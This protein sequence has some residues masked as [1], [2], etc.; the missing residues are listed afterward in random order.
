MQQNSLPDQN[1]QEMADAMPG[2]HD[3][4][5]TPPGSGVNHKHG[6]IVT[7]L[8]RK[9]SG[10]P[11]R[12]SL[13]RQVIV[14]R[15]VYSLPHFEHEYGYEQNNVTLYDKMKEKAR[16]NCYCSRKRLLDM[17][18]SFFPILHWLPRYDWKFNFVPDLLAGITVGV[19]SVPQGMAFARIA[20][21]SP[22]NGLYINFIPTLVYAVLGTSQHAAIGGEAVNSLLMG[23]M[24]SKYLPPSSG[25]ATVTSM[26][27][28]SSL[29]DEPIT[30]TALDLAMSA[31]MLEGLILLVMGMLRLGFISVY[32]SDQLVGG[33]TTGIAVHVLSTQVPALFGLVVSSHQ[34][35]GQLLMHYIEL[36]SMISDINWSTFIGSVICISFLLSVKL[37]V[38]PVAKRKLRVPIPSELIVVIVGTV[39]SYFVKLPERY[40]TKVVGEIPAGFPVP[41]LPRFDLMEKLVLDTLILAIVA[42]SL[43]VSLSK[44]Y[45]KKH[46]YKINP[47]QEFFAYS[48]MNIVGSFFQ[49]WPASNST[50]RILIYEGAGAKSQ[51]CLASMIVVA[52]IFM[53]RSLKDLKPLWKTCK[54]DFSIYLVTFLSVVLLDVSYGLAVSV[55]YAFFTVIIR[56]QCPAVR[57]L[58]SV[59]HAG[60]YGE[61]E[62][63][64]KVGRHSSYYL[65]DKAVAFRQAK[66]M[67]GIR[68]FHFTA[69]LYYANVGHF[70]PK[71]YKRCGINPEL[72]KQEQEAKGSSI[73]NNNFHHVVLDCSG[74][75]YVDL[76]GVD[77]LKQVY[78]ELK[79]HGVE[80]F[81][82]N[83]NATV[84]RMLE[85][86][87][88]YDVVPRQNI[89]ITLHDAVLAA[90]KMDRI[91]S[92][93]SIGRINPYLSESGILLFTL[94]HMSRHANDMRKHPLCSQVM[95]DTTT[96]KQI[97]KQTLK[98]NYTMSTL[99]I[100]PLHTRRCSL[101]QM[102]RLV[103]AITE[104]SEKDT[105]KL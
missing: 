27:N 19:V 42:Y 91:H 6:N 100:Q 40:R 101:V 69:P 67:P 35:A 68:V 5:I 18:Y 52:C 10:A 51:F 9:L 24:V 41:Y 12:P 81:L 63:Y 76:M 64:N 4:S 25:N 99:F 14:D 13:N 87:R 65:S 34:G 93:F 86:A 36:F 45:A 53:L 73:S 15:P 7:Y 71:L 50:S 11:Q 92:S 32:L 105:V 83:C 74:F 78:C 55:L 58:G 31:A 33:F 75:S 94:T 48:G 21:V 22:I 96:V 90:V 97:R 72:V 89:F 103:D 79:E 28:K 61:V 95:V 85:K 54:I 26:S 59:D 82:S 2:A 8:R 98:K 23:N 47:Y 49:C 37:L 16:K 66:A 56:T 57:E 3:R 1:R 30:F 60:L 104:I 70:K 102:E 17:L 88:F 44:M 84:R 39:V 80:L 29:L 46:N 38:D 62:V 77:V 20:G 43:S